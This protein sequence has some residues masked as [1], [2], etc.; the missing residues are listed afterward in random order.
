MS[1]TTALQLALA[2]PLVAGLAWLGLVRMPLL[3][4]VVSGLLALGAQASAGAVFWFVYRGDEVVWRSFQPELLG[5]SVLVIAEIGF[6]LAAV[7]ADPLPEGGNAPVIAGLAISASAIAAISYAGSLAVVAIALAIPTLAAAAAALS[8]GGRAA[9]R[10]LIGLAVADAVGLIGLSLVYARTGSIFV[11]DAGGAGPALLLVAA[12]LKAGA[13]PGVATWRLSGTDGPAAWLE[14]ALRGEAVALAAM[15]ALTMRGAAPAPAL[16]IVAAVA[17]L[18]AGA[19]AL[20]SKGVATSLAAVAGAA[21]GMPFLALGLGGAIGARAFLLL[22]PAF[23]LAA[24]LVSFLARPDPGEETGGE[25]GK[26]AGSAG[27][28]GWLAACALGVGLGSL[29]G[30][31]PGG[32]FPGTWLT[33]SLAASRSEATLAW[34]LATGAAGV[35]L[36]IAMAAAVGL[37]RAARPRLAHA[38]AGSLVALALLYLGTQ[39]IRIAIGWWIRIETALGLPE[40]LPTAGAPGLPAIGGLRLVLLLAPAVILVA[41]VIALGRRV[42][43]GGWELS[44]AP[45]F[46]GEPATQKIVKRLRRVVEPVTALA[47]P[48]KE[49][50]LRARALG[51]GFGIAAVLELAALLMVARIVLLSARSG[52]L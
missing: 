8:G 19:F 48:L 26:T 24:A 36:A 9:A 21:A 6:F 20:S 11:E 29:L 37:V 17:I 40:V 39:P 14:G 16:A 49:Y 12:L 7:R 43:D 33:L 5:A 46:P 22:F 28:W 3:R 38:A 32:A 31:P 50:A 23:L 1:G 41:A 44:V 25:R 2:G 15:A 52:F 30:M 34:L 35:G 10:G 18:A 13:V 51:V 45:H 47:R 42:R 27:M 4:R